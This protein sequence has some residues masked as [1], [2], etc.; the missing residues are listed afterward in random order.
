MENESKKSSLGQRLKDRLKATNV[1]SLLRAISIILVLL[2]VV[3]ASVMQLALDPSKLTWNSWL[4]STGVMV[5]ISV[6]G[7]FLGESWGKDHQRT[8][9]AGRYQYLL[10]Q[11]R[12]RVKRV[13]EGKLFSSFDKWY[14]DFSKKHE[15]IVM[16]DYLLEFGMIDSEVVLDNLVRFKENAVR[17][18]VLKHPV[19]MGDGKFVSTKTKEQ[20]QAIDDILNGELSLRNPS[21]NFYLTEYTYQRV[22]ILKA[23]EEINKKKKSAEVFGRGSRIVFSI[24]L[25]AFWAMITV[26]EFM[27]AGNTQAWMNLVSRIVAVFTS[28]FNGYL[29]GVIYVGLDGDLL[30][31]KTRVLDQFLNDVDNGTFKMRSQQED[32]KEEYEKYQRE[33]PVAKVEVVEKKDSGV[34][35]LTSGTEE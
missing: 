23:P 31:N 26:Q 32:A 9:S 3:I 13:D 5:A 7:I 20:L 12:E 14:L 34:R 24:V 25:S 1:K 21:S 11:F 2:L 30:D 22:Y 10:H 6:V 8:Y 18:D 35:L 16:N 4:A 33:H 29:N 28:I 27:D 17:E 19:K 15:R